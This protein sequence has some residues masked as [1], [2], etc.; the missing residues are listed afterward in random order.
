MGLLHIQPFP[1]GFFAIGSGTAAGIRNI[2]VENCQLGA[3]RGQ[4]HYG[5]N[6]DAGI[7]IKTERG[8]GG[9]IEDVTF[10]NITIYGRVDEWDL[11]PATP[12]RVALIYAYNDSIK[13]PTNISATPKLRRVR[14]ENI[15][16][17]AQCA[18]DFWRPGKPGAPS[19]CGDN[20]SIAFG[21]E[22]RIAPGVIWGL[23]D[24]LISEV[25][26]EN[27]T[28]ITETPSHAPWRCGHLDTD[29]I[30]ATDVSPPMT[31]CVR[32]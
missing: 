12:I 26:F 27:I 15:H 19:P 21:A 10:R 31:G 4:G 1:K 32:A 9:V 22:A 24:S 2:T 25:S 14:F 11:L 6:C 7:N 17:E 5:P 8:N 13:R 28:I 18:P 3:P 23:E 20:S 30:T 16:A 29:T